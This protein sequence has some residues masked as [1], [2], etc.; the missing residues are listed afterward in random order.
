MF[1]EFKNAFDDS[2]ADVRLYLGPSPLLLFQI[3]QVRTLVVDYVQESAHHVAYVLKN[4]GRVLY[5]C[6]LIHHTVV[7][8]INDF[9]GSRKVRPRYV[10]VT[11]FDRMLYL[12]RLVWRYL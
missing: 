4:G 5:F 3:L 6:K 10:L 9:K 12:R 11:L 2:F 1:L 7:N 8:L